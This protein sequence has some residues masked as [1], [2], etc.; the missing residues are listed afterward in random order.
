MKLKRDSKSNASIGKE[1]YLDG[2]LCWDF[3]GKTTCIQVGL[4]AP[5]REDELGR[6][7]L[8][9]NFGVTDGPNINLR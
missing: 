7:D 3:I 8:F 4:H 2:V 6:F 9:F 5:N 1:S